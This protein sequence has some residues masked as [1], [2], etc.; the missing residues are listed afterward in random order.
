MQMHQA[1][2]LYR[3]GK[4]RRQV[5]AALKVSEMPVRN[6]LAAF[7]I[8]PRPQ[9]EAASTHNRN[10]RGHYRKSQL[11]SSVFHLSRSSGA[12]VGM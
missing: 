8:K 6:A 11:V 1:A 7:G 9:R 10:K 3:E 5:A 4:S 12:M 2:E